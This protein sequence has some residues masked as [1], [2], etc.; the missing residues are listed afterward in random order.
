MNNL[1]YHRFLTLFIE[2]LRYFVFLFMKT[3]N[4]PQ[5]NVKVPLILMS[6]HNLTKAA[7]PD[8]D[9]FVIRVLS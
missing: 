5:N 4:T 7:D 9:P 3:S 1:S 6:S 2:W 8:D